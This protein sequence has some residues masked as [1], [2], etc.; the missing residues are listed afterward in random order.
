MPEH[1]GSAAVPEGPTALVM[2]NAD[3]GNSRPID[4]PDDRLEVLLHWCEWFLL[5]EPRKRGFAAA[6]NKFSEV[7]RESRAALADKGGRA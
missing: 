3:T 1:L 7:V 5:W 4:A 6:H 2:A